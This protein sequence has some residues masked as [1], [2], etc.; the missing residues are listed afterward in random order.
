MEWRILATSFRTETGLGHLWIKLLTKVG[1]TS[2]V[3][4][5]PDCGKKY[6]MPIAWRLIQLMMV[7]NQENA[8]ETQKK[9]NLSDSNW[10]CHVFFPK[11]ICHFSWPNL[12]SLC[13]KF[14]IKRYILNYGYLFW[15]HFLLGYSV[16]ATVTCPCRLLTLCQVKRNLYIIII[17][18]RNRC[19]N[20]TDFSIAWSVV[21][22]LLSTVILVHPT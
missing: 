15:G 21:C 8:P 10:H 12:L 22:H 18:V 19:S 1:Q 11:I 6:R 5:K 9:N 16:Y 4:C 3:D 14:L 2:A 13:L 20:A 7:I 17:F